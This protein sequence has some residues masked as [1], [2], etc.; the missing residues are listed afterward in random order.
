MRGALAAVNRS[1]LATAR[2]PSSPPTSATLGRPH[3]RALYPRQGVAAAPS[4]AASAS[5]AMATDPSSH[6]N[7]GDVRVT[8]AAFE[9]DVDFGR[10][11][12]EGF[13]TLTAA[14]EAEAGAAELVLDSRDLHV[15]GVWHING[16]DETKLE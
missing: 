15:T 12:L 6:A 7:F 10:R 8:R 5:V 14:V 11:V 16:P 1:L 4:A 9:L 2:P 3:R 13:V